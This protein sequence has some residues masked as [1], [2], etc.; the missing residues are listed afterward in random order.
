MLEKKHFL[1]IICGGIACIKIPSLIKKIRN[2]GHSVQCIVTKAGSEFVSLKE[3]ETISANKVLLDLFPSNENNKFD[4]IF[5]SRNADLVIV[6]PATA[7]IIA[8]MANGIADDLASST[9]LACNKQVIIAPSMNVVMWENPATKSN[10]K[11][12]TGYGVKCIGPRAGHLACGETGMGRMAEVDEIIAFLEKYQKNIKKR[13]P[14]LG[15]KAI[16]TSGP[17]QE[18]IDPV[19]YI[20]NHSSGRQGH[21]IASAMYALGAEVKLITGPTN[22]PDPDGVI[23]L[24]IKSGKE[25]LETC[26]SNLPADIFISAAAVSDWKVKE[27]SE[28]KI[29]K[30]NKESLSFFM[31]KNPDILKTISTMEEGR[32]NLVVGFAAET[33]NI[34]KNAKKK[35]IEKQCDWIIANDVSNVFGSEYNK[36]HLVTSKNTESWPKL[37]KTEVANKLSEKIV[38]YIK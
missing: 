21:A 34:V 20:S 10:I 11:K 6:A 24:H 3:L 26:I 28:N 36:V 23:V 18:A 15:L 5:L 32:P 33:D 31:V 13:K 25:M 22:Q 14:L 9:L 1:L 4:H 29:K 8:K 7:N 37:K 35:L 12:I 17:T 19:R 38:E 16:V 2:Q 30:T 27:F